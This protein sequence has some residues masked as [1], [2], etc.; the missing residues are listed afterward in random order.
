M[1]ED[2]RRKTKGTFEQ[3]AFDMGG[4]YTYPH[5]YQQCVFTLQQIGKSFKESY[6]VSQWCPL[7]FLCFP[8]YRKV[9]HYWR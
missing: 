9:R 3:V 2:S 1:I 5:G 6:E 7:E 4:F 8:E